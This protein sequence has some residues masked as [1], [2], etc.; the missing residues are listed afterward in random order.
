SERNP[1]ILADIYAYAVNDFNEPACANIAEGSSASSTGPWSISPSAQSYSKYLTATNN[2]QSTSV[3]FFPDIKQ[4]GNYSVTIYTPGCIGDGTC[5]TRGRV[6]ITG[7]MAA[8][9]SPSQL[10][11]TE[12]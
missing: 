1:L 3:V 9:A 11:N 2:S 7:T 4:S 5:A 8:A 12:I 10:V 6:N